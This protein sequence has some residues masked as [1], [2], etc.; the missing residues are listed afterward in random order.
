MGTQFD[1]LLVGDNEE[2]LRGAWQ[3]I[4]SSL[5]ELQ[6]RLSRFEEGGE[7]Y[8]LNQ[9]ATMGYVE[10]SNLM[11]SVLSD[12]EQHYH[13]TEG[14]F[15]IT[16][17]RHEFLVLDE[18]S[19]S[20]NFIDESMSIDLG[21]YGKGCALDMVWGVLEDEGIESAFVNFGNSS[22]L[23]LGHHPCGDWWPISVADPFTKEVL[24]E[25]Q[26]SDTT[27][28]VS[29]NTPSHTQHIVNPRTGVYDGR[30]RV[31]AIECDDP[32][33]GEALSTAAMSMS[34]EQIEG[35]RKHARSI[36]VSCEL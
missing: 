5:F 19:R 3:R 27:L 21:G 14:F 8:E 7:L 33:L 12:C 6:H 22:I 9:N 36:F 4:E 31:V 24:K 20:I 29:G 16:L 26:L 10:V 17:G 34:D 30:Q 13:T 1:A 32:K 2:Q 35:L 15:D 28:T 18:E 23:A 11:W 25:Y